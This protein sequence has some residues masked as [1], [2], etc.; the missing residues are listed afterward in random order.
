M[1]LV[2]IVL[3]SVFVI[4]DN[5]SISMEYPEKVVFEEEFEIIVSLIDFE[6]DL[7]DVKFE[8]VNGSKNLARRYYEGEWKSSN[9]WMNQAINNS[10][11]NE[12][13]FNLIISEEYDGINNFSIKIRNQNDFYF[14]R[15]E[16]INISYVER[17]VQEEDEGESD[18]DENSSDSD[19]RVVLDWD[20]DDIENGKRFDIDVDISGLDEKEYD[21]RLWVEDDGNVISD[22]QNFN[23]KEWKSGKFYLDNILVGPGNESLEVKLRIRE[24][25]RDFDGSARVYFKLREGFEISREI[26]VLEKRDEEIEELEV[27]IPKSS[28]VSGNVVKLDAIKLGNTKLGSSDTNGIVR[29]NLESNLEY[30]SNTEIVKSYSLYAFALLC[31]IM[32]ILIVLRKLE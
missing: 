8:I 32:S 30:N 10:V 11:E 2:M 17:N 23:D 5:L 18:N 31:V 12:K 4:A 26:K 28:K 19:I 16:L 7:Y 13:S 9:F 21:V 3:F 15:Y 1:L 27:V 24:D 25:Y 6:F 14:E 29:E 22:R 20:K